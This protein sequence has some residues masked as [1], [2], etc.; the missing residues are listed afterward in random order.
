MSARAD[1]SALAIGAAPAAEA[2]WHKISWFSDV[3]TWGRQSSRLG[4]G[5]AV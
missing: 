1:F 3:F 2:Q 4:A 5:L